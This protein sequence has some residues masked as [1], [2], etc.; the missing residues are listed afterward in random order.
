MFIHNHGEYL[1]RAWGDELTS[2]KV[3][4]KAKVLA[5]G[6]SHEQNQGI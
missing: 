2:V 4:F 1:V 3:I 6:V 5:K